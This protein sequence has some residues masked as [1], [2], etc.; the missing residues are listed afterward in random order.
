VDGFKLSPAR[1]QSLA[2]R[3]GQLVQDRPLEESGRQRH[4]PVTLQ[5]GEQRVDSSQSPAEALHTSARI[6]SPTIA[7]A[8]TGLLRRESQPAS[9]AADRRPFE[10]SAVTTT[11]AMLRVRSSPRHVEAIDPREH[12]VEYERIGLATK[13]HF[14]R[15][16]A[17]GRNDCAEP[18]RH[19]L[20]PQRQITGE[21]VDG[22]YAERRQQSRSSVPGTGRK[23]P[24]AAR[25]QSDAKRESSSEQGSGL[26]GTCFQ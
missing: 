9:S 22:G 18:I 14:D 23:W 16:L 8:R 7:A 13:C 26:N 6:T 1:P 24:R 10:V 19:Q 17:V 21:T 5:C 12:E 15:F 4:A 20:C 2:N 11:M 25:R 3:L